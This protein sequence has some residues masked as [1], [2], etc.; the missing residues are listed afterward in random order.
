MRFLFLSYLSE[1]QIVDKL[2]QTLKVTCEKEMANIVSNCDSSVVMTDSIV[3][4]PSVTTHNLI[5]NCTV[6]I[7]EW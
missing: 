5:I 3:C 7:T 1:D 4:A 6:T 2:D